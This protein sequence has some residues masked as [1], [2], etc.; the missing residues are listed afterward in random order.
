MGLA[1][2]SIFKGLICIFFPLISR[3]IDLLIRTEP[4]VLE[5]VKMLFLVKD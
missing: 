5:E 1:G 2:G 3:P 4:L